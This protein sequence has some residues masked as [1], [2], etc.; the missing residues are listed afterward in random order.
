MKTSKT[1]SCNFRCAAICLVV[2]GLSLP[3]RAQAA[4]EPL[5]PEELRGD[6]FEA[7]LASLFDVRAPYQAAKKHPRDAAE[8]GCGPAAGGGL[9]AE[10]GQAPAAKIPAGEA[11]TDPLAA[12]LAAL[13]DVSAPAKAKVAAP[14]GK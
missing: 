2:T 10:A 5:K 3:I 8:S 12:E 11:K 7:E 1:I 6:K 4:A 14:G 13:W 9:K